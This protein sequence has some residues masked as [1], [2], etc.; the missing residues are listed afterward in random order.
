LITTSEEDL[1]EY[2]MNEGLVKVSDLKIRSAIYSDENIICLPNSG[3][4]SDPHILFF[5]SGVL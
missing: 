4:F 5:K 3:S 1:Y 2:T